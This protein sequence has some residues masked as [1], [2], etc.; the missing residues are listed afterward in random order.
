MP[1]LRVDGW[2]RERP[3]APDLAP[4]LLHTWRGN[5]GDAELPLPD[6]RVDLVWVSDG[7]LW[8]SGPETRSWSDRHPP[9][10]TAVGV[11]FR[12]GTGPPLLHVAASEIRD[13]RVRLDE[14]WGNREADDLTAR[15]AARADDRGRA[16]ELEKA[17]RRRAGAALP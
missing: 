8:V 5:L 6:E 11:A 1:M 14:V 12:P 2:L 9:G 17:V 7:S 10:T 3:P 15:V 4:W 13:V 16:E